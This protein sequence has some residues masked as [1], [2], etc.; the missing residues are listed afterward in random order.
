MAETKVVRAGDHRELIKKLDQR[1]AKIEEHT[2]KT[3]ESNEKMARP[4][5]APAP[6]RGRLR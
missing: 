4:N 1:P 3:A 2:K 6:L 5:A